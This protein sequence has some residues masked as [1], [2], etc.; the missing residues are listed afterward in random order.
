MQDNIKAI[1]F[2][3]TGNWKDV[4]SMSAVPIPLPAKGEVQVHIAARPINPSDEMFISGNY[5]KKPLFPQ[6]AGLE[7]AGIIERTGDEVDSSLTGRKVSFRAVGTWAEKINLPVQNIRL[8]P[9]EIPLET[10]AQL[11][12]NTITAWAL[13]EE[14]GL[15][16]EQ[17]LLFNAAASA[18]GKQVIQ[19]AKTKG[20]RTIAIVRKPEQA[21]AL[22]ALGAWQ[23]LVW[24]KNETATQ[25]LQLTGSGV[26]AILDAVGGEQGSLFYKIMAPFGKLIIYGRLDEGMSYYQN[27]DI[28][29][30]NITIQGFGIDAWLQRKTE[31]EK[32]EIWEKLFELIRKNELN[33]TADRSYPLNEFLNAIEDYQQTKAKIILH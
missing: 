16:K 5:R 26:H 21:A 1:R 13:L 30:R 12:L 19:L 33:I 11:S 3:E 29:Y 31:K 2:T 22:Y 8:I 32:D 18:V 24:D 6:V 7:G 25:V 15:H 20:I 17:F 27:G 23:V 9:D 10:A 14:A 28:I 4:L